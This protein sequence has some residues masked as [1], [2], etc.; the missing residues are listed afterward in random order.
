M[1]Y[2]TFPIGED[3]IE[4]PIPRSYKDCFHLIQSDLH[5]TNSGGGIFKILLKSFISR[6]TAFHLWLRLAQY[7]DGFFYPYCNIRYELI[8]K[9]YGIHIPSKTLIGYGLYLGHY[10]GICINGSTIIGNNVNLS[11]F[12]S[13][14]A[15]EGK[16]AII[17]D[18][19]YIG[20]NTCLVENITIGNNCTIG[21][22]AVVVKDIPKNATAVGVPARILHYEQ[23]GRFIGHPWIK[24][25]S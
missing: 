25:I 18:N 20:P 11:Q 10:L 6:R 13:I 21:A 1:D 2:K 5:R 12:T 14:G 16:A 7:K 24:R 19:V 9:K 8:Q 4:I 17:G 15:N 23:A 22:G 3:I